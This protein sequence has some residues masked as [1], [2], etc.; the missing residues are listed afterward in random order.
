MNVKPK[1]EKQKTYENVMQNKR[2]FQR[3]SC[4]RQVTSAIGKSLSVFVVSLQDFSTFEL[5]IQFI[6]EHT[7]LLLLS[8]INK[9]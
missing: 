1:P 5:I 3:P 7:V 2:S 9:F 4:Q 6:G 8:F